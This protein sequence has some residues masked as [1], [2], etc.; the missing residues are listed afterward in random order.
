MAYTFGEHVLHVERRELWRGGELV[1]LEPQVFDLLVYLV[2]HR[3][4]VVGKD[5]LLQ[6]VWGGRIV[7]DSALTTRINAA[8]RALGDN[9]ETQR[10]IRTLPRKGIRFVADVKEAPDGVRSTLAAA[11]AAAALGTRLLPSD[12]PSIAVLPFSGIGGGAKQEAFADGMV[13]EIITALSRIRWL[14]VIARSSSFSYKGQ[15]VDARRVGRE[16]GVRYIL[17]GSVRKSGGR[18]G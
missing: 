5:D 14:V 12:K 11:R 9:G 6:A 3:D 17:D 16:L 7:S 4:R 1:E 18:V 13:E 10:L 2:R 15:M 8:R